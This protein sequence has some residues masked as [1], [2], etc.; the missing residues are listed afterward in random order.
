V[1]QHFVRLKTH[2]KVSQHIQL[3][4]TTG[5]D[6]AEFA[7][8]GADL[9]DHLFLR[10]SPGMGEILAHPVSKIFNVSRSMVTQT[11][12]SSQDPMAGGVLYIL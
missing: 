2:S 7:G 9:G 5:K 8:D 10:P 6:H 12:K 11:K 4:C 3:S 1:R